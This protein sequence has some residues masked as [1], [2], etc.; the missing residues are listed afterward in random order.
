MDVAAGTL[1]RGTTAGVGSGFFS[2]GGAILM[3]LRSMWARCS[4]R[5]DWVEE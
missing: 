1:G 5:M 2:A 3:L 4:M